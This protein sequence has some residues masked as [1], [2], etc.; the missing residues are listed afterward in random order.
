MEDYDSTQP[1]DFE[2][3]RKSVFT[4]T[5]SLWSLIAV[6]SGFGN[7]RGY[8]F[9]VMQ[10]LEQ[11]A[12]GNIVSK[13]NEYAGIQLLKGQAAVTRP[14]LQ[15][16]LR[17]SIGEIVRLGA[18]TH[19]SLLHDRQ[20]KLLKGEMLF[21]LPQ[22]QAPFRIH[23]P[24]TT[25]EITQKGV[26]VAQVTTNGGL[27][28]LSLQGSIRLHLEGENHDLEPGKLYFIPPGPSRLGKHLHFNL[29][30]FLETTGLVQ[31]F[32]PSLPVQKKM[33]NTAFRQSFFIH[34]Q[35][36]LFVGDAKSEEDFDL[37]LLKP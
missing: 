8:K 24:Q 14:G 21:Y 35:T 3:M 11:D 27:K 7:S 17:S 12:K 37:L 2:P 32:Q 19:F 26:L 5:L 33:E 10:W 28:L 23:G 36:R 15:L 25:V 1:S 20:I 9:E 31:N 22:S 13:T 34:K 16:E 29:K 4:L 30:L 6:S 18:D